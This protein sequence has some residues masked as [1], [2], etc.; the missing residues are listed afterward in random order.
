MP[1]FTPFIYQLDNTFSL[2][3]FPL[4]QDFHDNHEVP[5]DHLHFSDTRQTPTTNLRSGSLQVHYRACSTTRLSG[6]SLWEPP[7]PNPSAILSDISPPQPL[8]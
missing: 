4:L 3:S 5:E 2:T 7:L 8:D 1:I 6:H